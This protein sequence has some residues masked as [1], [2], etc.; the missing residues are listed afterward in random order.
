MD[1]RIIDQQ[2]NIHIPKNELILR[3]G[4]CYHPT[5]KLFK[6]R[7]AQMVLTLEDSFDI[8]EKEVQGYEK[9]LCISDERNGLQPGSVLLEQG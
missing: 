7:R 4:T 5:L 2:R 3:G 1:F 8:Q 6:E 9:V